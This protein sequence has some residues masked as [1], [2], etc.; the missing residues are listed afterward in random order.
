MKE[1]YI[2]GILKLP[3]EEAQMVGRIENNL[4][5][6]QNLVEGY[7][8]TVTMDDCVV[9]CNEEG[10]LMGMKPNCEFRGVDFVGPIV[11]VGREYDEFISLKALDAVPIAIELN[12][13]SY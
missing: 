5:A 1:K 2:T 4:E 8:E 6:L 10:R 11:V 3:G 12:E 7:I 9:I 13:G